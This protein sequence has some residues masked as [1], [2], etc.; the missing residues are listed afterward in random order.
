MPHLHEN[1]HRFNTAGL[2]RGKKL[3]ITAIYSLSYNVMQKVFRLTLK[4]TLVNLCV[5]AACIICLEW[6]RVH[7]LKQNCF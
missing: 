7:I 5:D 1:V 3:V 4:L 6:F 2:L